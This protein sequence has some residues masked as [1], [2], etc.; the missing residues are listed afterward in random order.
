MDYSAL[1]D[2]YLN[3][4]K[5]SKRLEK[6]DLIADLLKKSGKELA[7]IA[8]LLQGKVFP[9][10]D[11]KKIGMSSR[12]I[13]KV[14]GKSSGIP[15]SEVENLWRKK[16]DLGI[17]AEEV[18]KHKKQATL[19]HRELEVFKVF[20]NIQKLASIEGERAIDRKIGLVA[21]LLSDARPVEA[22]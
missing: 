1:V 10:Y 7:C 15:V 17:V 8:N 11:E 12:L 9:H 14:I 21:E 16:G 18:M 2:V 5:T 4:E 6:V 13:L 20:D 22:R 3:L 19:R